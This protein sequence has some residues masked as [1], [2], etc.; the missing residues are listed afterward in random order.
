MLTRHDQTVVDCL[1]A[2]DTVRSI[3]V[4]H[5][6]FKDVGVPMETLIALNQAIKKSG[7]TSYLEVVSETPEGCVRSARNAVEIGID[8]LMGGTEIEPT[9]RILIGLTLTHF[10]WLE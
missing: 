9:F 3:G 1:E 4:R 6:G 2:F 5:V 7:A 10:R 8:R